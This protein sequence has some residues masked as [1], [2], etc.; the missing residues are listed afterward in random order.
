MVNV[1]LLNGRDI[2]SR[3]KAQRV[4]CCINSIEIIGGS[5]CGALI[6]TST[7]DCL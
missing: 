3:I 2:V 7:A 1:V 4:P 6:I 5:F